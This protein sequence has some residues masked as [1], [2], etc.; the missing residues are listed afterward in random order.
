MQLCVC[1][2]TLPDMIV[3]DYM[4]AVRGFSNVL[5]TLDFKRKFQS[6]A[7]VMLS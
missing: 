4:N 2:S 6:W 3:R 7:L 5:V 1:V